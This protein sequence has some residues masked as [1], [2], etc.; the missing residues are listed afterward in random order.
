MTLEECV[1]RNLICPTL[2]RGWGGRCRGG[3]TD[4]FLEMSKNV[5]GTDFFPTTKKEPQVQVMLESTMGKGIH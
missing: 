3:D 4:I 1:L 2:C 5:R